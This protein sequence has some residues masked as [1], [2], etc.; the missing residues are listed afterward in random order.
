[1]PS[2]VAH[3]WYLVAAGCLLIV[4]C[5]ASRPADSVLPEPTDPISS[6]MSHADRAR[7]ASLAAARLGDPSDEGYRIGPD[8]LL[9]IRIRDLF[10]VD[11]GEASM[12]R[13]GL[14]SGAVPDVS[15]APS[16]QQGLRV[17]ADGEVNI[18]GVGVIRASGDTPHELEQRLARRLFA[19]G[20][21]QR[22]QVS[23]AVIEYRSNVVAVVGSVQRPG[24]YPLT[25]PGAT[26]A[27]MVWAAGGPTREAGRIVQFAPAGG[28]QMRP[29]RAAA[30]AQR[31]LAPAQLA[32]AFPA[33][34]TNGVPDAVAVSS[35]A[36]P[37]PATEVA[38]GS[39]API[40]IDLETLLQA[41]A[42]GMPDL[43][44]PARPG[45]VI[46][47]VPAGTVLVSGW[48]DKPGPY[49]ITRSL[50]LAGAVAAAGGHSFAAD[51]GH[52]TVRRV[53][54]TREEHLFV[55]DLEAITSGREADMPMVDGDVVTLPADNLRLVPWG[56]WTFVSTV[57]RVG[58]S[59]AV[60]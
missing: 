33:A 16:F 4:G 9:D 42:Q 44:P 36:Q 12:R 38:T 1:M 17:T 37:L 39:K 32:S 21:L 55:R 3:R 58:W 5:N 54:G 10:D 48:V 22:P 43:N 40:R 11:A 18:P 59:L 51:Q 52:V 20:I 60:L 8:D 27:D 26:I 53:L 25:R 13:G 7:L 14:T 30:G 29:G 35:D 57:F 34:P 31:P 23:V 41:T 47:L 2:G 45:D 50:T 24:V 6:L 49:A 56:L 15:A 46:N 19:D 28:L